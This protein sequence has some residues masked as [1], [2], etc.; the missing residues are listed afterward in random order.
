[1]DTL[2][3]A[4]QSLPR[5]LNAKLLLV[6]EIEENHRLSRRTRAGIHDDPHILTTGFADDVSLWYRVMD[7]VVLPSRRE[8]LPNVILEAAAS[9]LPCIATDATGC[10][11]ALMDGVTGI[12]VPV[13]RPAELARAMMRLADDPSLR[14][15]MGTAGRKLVE[16]HYSQPLVWANTADFIGG[17]VRRPGANVSSPAD[18][19]EVDPCVSS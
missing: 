7:I 16:D 2:V 9:G 15:R 12:V 6:G 1:V 11:D 17:L 13:G 10:R 19:R 5:R 18:A 8:G 14:A 4:F 3:D